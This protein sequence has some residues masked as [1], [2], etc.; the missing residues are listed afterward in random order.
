[1][2]K[3]KNTSQKSTPRKTLFLYCKFLSLTLII[4]G[5]CISLISA[6]GVQEIYSHF[7]STPAISM[8]FKDASLKDILKIFSIQSGVNFI[9]SQDI[10]DR[11][12]TLYLDNVSVK[13]ALDKLFKA[14]NLAYEFDEQ[15]KIILVKKA[16]LELETITKVFP[17]KYASVSCSSIQTEKSDNLGGE[18]V[19]E[20]EETEGGITL[21][22]RALLSGSGKLTEEPRTNSL[23]ITDLP[24]RF[25]IIEKTIKQL[26]IPV[27]QVMLEVEIL[28]VKKS[29]VDKMGFTFGNSGAFGENP[30][31]LILPG[32]FLHKEAK[33]FI[34]DLGK[35]GNQ[36]DS[37][38][39]QG[40]VIFGN[41]FAGL[42]DFL[43]TRTDTRY[44]ARPRI[45]TLNNETAEIEI[46]TDEVI[47]EKLEYDQEGFVTGRSAERYETGVTLRI[48]PQINL[49]TSEITMFL[50]P[51]VTEAATSNISGYRDPEERGAKCLV[52]VRDAETVVV[53][54]LIRYDKYEVINK[55]PIL[56]DIPIIGG[57]FR[58]KDKQKDIERELLV[59]ITPHILKGDISLSV[60]QESNVILSSREQDASS[61]KTRSLSIEST[62]DSFDAS[63]Y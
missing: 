4:F 24:N 16:G 27:P 47:G 17:L 46:T 53:G 9:C 2:S 55:I 33:Y 6:Q 63:E 18:D 3:F 8:D 25:A 20:G 60:A 61:K 44:L 15:A 39:A 62:L 22:I 48:T 34:G 13:E 37:T 58:H 54:G 10:E 11:T 36:L 31:T 26:D 59:F 30:L 50:M 56:G 23:I 29:I 7:D 51:K 28:D 52:R 21:A 12:V 49:E 45:L 1:M 5:F 38:G 40:S 32:A 42:L 41:T 14:N 35:K 57:L 19:E 43:R